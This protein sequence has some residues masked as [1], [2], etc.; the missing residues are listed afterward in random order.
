[1]RAAGLEIAATLSALYK[2]DSESEKGNVAN[3]SGF[4]KSRWKRRMKQK[5]P[6]PSVSSMRVF[7]ALHLKGISN[8]N[9]R[10]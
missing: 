3:S 10:A 7:R 1:M 5:W 6:I 2:A 4:Y 8:Q 9:G